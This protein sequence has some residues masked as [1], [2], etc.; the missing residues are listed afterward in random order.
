MM[1]Y[2]KI[3]EK[4]LQIIEKNTRAGFFVDP[5]KPLNQVYGIDSL[6]LLNVLVDVE[7]EFGI[8]FD[9]AEDLDAVFYS[10]RTICDYLQNRG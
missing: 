8:S 1:D 2:A 9:I 3:Q 5:D 10:A 4:V 7:N 6:T